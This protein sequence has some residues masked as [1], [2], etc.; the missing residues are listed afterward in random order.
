MSILC[1]VCTT[2]FA[3]EKKCA[4]QTNIT[5]ANNMERSCSCTTSNMTTISLPT[6]QIISLNM[7]STV[8]KDPAPD[9]DH[10]QETPEMNTNCILPILTLPRGRWPCR[11][12][13]TTNRVSSESGISLDLRLLTRYYLLHHFHLSH[14]QSMRIHTVMGGNSILSTVARI[15][16]PGQWQWMSKGHHTRYLAVLSCQRCGCAP[17]QDV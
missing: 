10:E 3:N 13:P 6:C 12:S 11:P 5:P 9:L 4:D 8:E 17:H 15:S 14:C 16:P 7:Y 1:S 2:L